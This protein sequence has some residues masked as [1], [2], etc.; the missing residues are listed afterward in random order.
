MPA[1]APKAACSTR[2]KAALYCSQGQLLRA[3]DGAAAGG[4][5]HLRLRPDLSEMARIWKGGCIIRAELL[6][7]IQGAFERDPNLDNLLLDP[8]FARDASTPPTSSG[9]T[10]A[11]VARDLG[12]P[13]PAMSASLDYFD[14]YRSEQL[15][16]NLIQGLA[17]LL[18]RAHLPPHRQGR[19]LPHDL[20][21]SGRSR[22][23]RRRRSPRRTP[24]RP[25][26]TSRPWSG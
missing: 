17:R 9:A 23:R 18:R 8:G 4:V 19:D 26:R 16:A 25:A 15:P 7:T 10:L 11:Q 2:S 13:I 14:S 5:G 3:G 1:P 24:A 22:Q 12:V 21:A 6:D 20:G